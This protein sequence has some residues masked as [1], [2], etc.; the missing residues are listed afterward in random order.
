MIE[1]NKELA[2]QV[3]KLVKAGSNVEAVGLVQKIMQCGLKNA[4]EYVD[5]I[6]KKY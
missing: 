4:K 1:V 2:D 3:E 6:R 5:S